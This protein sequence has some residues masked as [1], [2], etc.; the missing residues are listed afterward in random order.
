MTHFAWFGYTVEVDEPATRDYYA[1][2]E[3][4]GCEC[5]HCRNFVA[6][7]RE[8]KL[9]EGLLAILDSVSIPPE[10]ATYVCELCHD[11]NWREKGL[12]YELSWRV[13]GTILDKPA[14]KDNGQEWGPLVELPWGGMIL[15]HETFPVEPEFP[16]PHF[17]LEFTLYLPWVLEEHVDSPEKKKEDAP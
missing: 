15:G 17:D 1:Q 8:R 7:A 16:L 9:P 6:L 12:L 11:E 13:A 5:G 3:D 2:A 4:W 14:R 10:K